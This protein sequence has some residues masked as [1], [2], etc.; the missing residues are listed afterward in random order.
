MVPFYKIRTFDRGHATILMHEECFIKKYNTE[1]NRLKIEN[2]NVN[3][4]NRCE[5]YDLL[6]F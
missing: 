3:V 5:S 1:L 2:K 4:T 6:T